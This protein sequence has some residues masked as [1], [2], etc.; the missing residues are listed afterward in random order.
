MLFSDTLKGLRGETP[1]LIA[2]RNWSDSAL[3]PLEDWPQSL[4]TALTTLLLSPVPIVMLWGAEGVMLY[5]DA[6]SIFAGG[7]H[8]ELLGSK[9]REGWPEVAEFNDNVMKTGLAGGTLQYR[10]QELTLYRHGRPENVW[11]NLDYSPVLGEDGRPAGVLAIVVETTERVLAEKA[12]AAER[13]RAAES[14]ARFQNM[15]DNAPVMLW[16]TDPSG[17]CTY[18]NRSWYDFTGQTR[19]E[20]VGYGWLEATHPDDRE[21]AERIFRDANASRT[22][23]RMDY[24]LRRA[25][26][27]YRWCIDAAA[28]RLSAQGEYLGYIGSVIDIDERREAERLQRESELRLRVIT[29]TLPSFVWFAAPDGE[30]HYF[31]DRWYEY[32]GQTPETALPN[33]WTGTLHPD[34]A[35]RVAR[36]WETARAAGLSYE[37]ECRYR[38]NDGAFRWYVARAEAL[39]NAEGRITGWVGSS[40]DIHDR[41]IAEGQQKLLI[42]ELNHRVKNTLATVQSLATQSAAQGRTTAE[43]RNL[44]EGRLLSLSAAHNLLTASNW[45]GVSLPDLVARALDPW[46]VGSRFVSAGPA[47]WLS[48]RQALSISMALHE[49]ATNAAKYGALSAPDGR[50]EISWSVDGGRL[51]LHWREMGGPEVKA[52]LRRGFGSRLLEHGIGRELGAEASLAFKPNGLEFRMTLSLHETGQLVDA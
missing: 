10:D 3:G 51:H 15:A 7:R 4:R 43:Y 11:M 6:Y 22:P 37:T 21:M 18:L 47:V 40:S 14:E 13:D 39:R 49:L 17:Y 26:G 31:N 50:V 28:P 30:L 48:P 42:N 45:E 16:V 2:G 9:V 20:A 8:P 46:T 36:E 44:F 52:P 19:G 32:T 34:D 23:F 29:N 25:D 12:M 38:R 5:N 1:G 35:D 41:V 27:T 33:G 24:R